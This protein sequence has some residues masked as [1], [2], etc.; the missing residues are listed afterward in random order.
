MRNSAPFEHKY[1]QN[2]KKSYKHYGKCDE[3]Q[4]FKYIHEAAIVS[5]P[6]EFTNT[7]PR[8]PMTPTTVLK[9]AL[10]NHCVFSLTC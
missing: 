8:Y 6:E 9:K 1:I 7:S 2:I 3:Q 4:Q 10:E 5:T